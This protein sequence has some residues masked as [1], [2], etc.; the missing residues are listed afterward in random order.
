MLLDTE[1]KMLAGPGDFMNFL[2]CMG[3]AL[4]EA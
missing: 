4:P 1:M 2:V 3:P